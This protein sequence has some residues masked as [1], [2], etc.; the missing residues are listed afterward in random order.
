MSAAIYGS[1][2]APVPAEVTLA[3]LEAFNRDRAA[4]AA[5][6][7]GPTPAPGKPK[8]ELS[9]VDKMALEMR[10]MARALNVARAEAAEW[11]LLAADLGA[12]NDAL[13]SC[14]SRGVVPGWTIR[15]SAH[16]RI[17][18]KVKARDGGHTD[19]EA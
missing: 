2:G 8:G 11:R 13:R 19:E 3:G 18:V 15:S 1:R 17:P 5:R 10:A 14:I 9:A 12:D 7:K 6:A 4:R 16:G